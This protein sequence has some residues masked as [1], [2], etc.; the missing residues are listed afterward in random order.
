M[1]PRDD[2]TPPRF[3]TVAEVAQY[4]HVSLAAPRLVAKSAVIMALVATLAAPA[5]A[6]TL[7]ANCPS[8][9][10][11]AVIDSANS[12]DTILIAGT[13]VG[14][15]VVK[16]KSITLRRS[17]KKAAILDGNGVGTVLSV[18]GELGFP[19][20]VSVNGLVVRNGD[21]D[22]INIGFSTTTLKNI[23]VTGNRRYGVAVLGIATII[24]SRIQ[25]NGVG[26]QAG[27]EF[28]QV[29]IIGSK[30]SGNAGAGVLCLNVIHIKGSTISNN[31]G[32]IG[33]AKCVLTV[34]N[35]TVAKN[36]CDGCDGAGIS[37]GHD[38]FLSLVNSSV[39]GN[40]SK[41]STFGGGGIFSAD[42]SSLNITGSTISGNSTDGSGGGIF[43]EAGSFTLDDSR[44]AHNNAGINGGGLF[45][46]P[47]YADN[48][49]FTG[50]DAIRRNRAGQ[51]GGGVCD[52]SGTVSVPAGIVTRN[53]PDDFC[54]P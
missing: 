52:Q 13:C 9:D 5:F 54:K 29:T 34:T 17:G 41:N 18:T 14:Q 42:G 7:L 51:D 38:G 31:G 30:V 39:I 35:S 21:V 45:I 26:V 23:T 27:G 25:S 15:F 47:S 44:V 33:I 10:L 50:S 32:G 3:M 46:W 37:D 49:A 6:N 12:G 11:Q 19:P 2:A 1:Y 53:S 36:V 48:A 16:D 24:S 43:L 8:T 22:G 28:G 40:I 20:D 4:L